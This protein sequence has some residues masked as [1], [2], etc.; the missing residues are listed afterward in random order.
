MLRDETDLRRR[1]IYI[2]RT[3][4]IHREHAVNRIEPIALAT[5]NGWQPVR[6]TTAVFPEE[7]KVFTFD[8][9]LVDTQDYIVLFTIKR[10]DRDGADRY[11]TDE[12]CEPYQIL[13]EFEALSAD[14]RR[15]R[16]TRTGIDR[17]FV[18]PG[19]VILP[20]GNGKCAFPHMEF[21]ATENG[22]I[23]PLSENLAKIDVFRGDLDFMGARQTIFGRHFALPGRHPTQ[24][25]GA[26][27]WES[28][29]ECFEAI[30]RLL[31]RHDSTRP[32]GELAQVSRQVI[33]RLRAA[34]TNSEL[35][36]G[37]GR[38]VAALHERLAILLPKLQK[39]IEYVDEIASTLAD[40][41]EVKHRVQAFVETE[42]QAALEAM[43]DELRAEVRA[44]L[45]AELATSEE[46][47]TKIR[48]EILELDGRRS[49]LTMELE[50]LL[51]VRDV[52]LKDIRT[53]ISSI[54]EEV[55]KGGEGARQLLDVAK[56]FGAAKPAPS[57]E[58]QTDTPWSRPVERKGS[59][60]AL[61]QIPQRIA[62]AA[63]KM[64][65]DVESMAMLDVTVR[66]GEVG[67]LAG[68]E[69]PLMLDVYAEAAF[70][71][72]IRRM[73]LDPSVLG[74]EDLWTHPLRKEATT[75]A[76]AWASALEQP[77]LGHL[78]VLEDV[79]AA[80]LSDWFT[81]FARLFRRCRPA[82]LMIVATRRRMSIEKQKSPESPEIVLT[83]RSSNSPAAALLV[84]GGVARV[85]AG[86]L[87]S[88]FREEL[89]NDERI[90]LLALCSEKDWFHPEL[91]ARLYALTAA[92]KAWRAAVPNSERLPLRVLG[93]D[94]QK[95][96]ASH[97]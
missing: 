82:N 32:G 64:G 96:S 42:K 59:E 62:A 85:E 18:K 29:P 54:A 55:W 34:Y 89:E 51:D 37:D 26:V 24:I 10:N 48:S 68:H 69:A 36:E 66:S 57:R 94:P 23:V 49:N 53:S 75:L 77:L 70:G 17:L 52:R 4:F 22:W 6:N 58:R 19:G 33:Q 7:G 41:P 88:P 65:F 40:A 28:D 3:L 30:A 79:D 31:K 46:A 71:G 35:L 97:D 91:A 16:A 5:E 9:R 81:T 93:L 43:K 72:S 56:Q 63:Q 90:A 95:E 78:V 44:S 92:A 1:S 38:E 14:E 67:I 60:F 47:K 13:P 84:H 73:P 2:G 21:D 80:S 25:D 86:S 11:L 27:N 87:T 74:A 12:V 15:I 20:L 50:R 83:P 76:L 8:P 39:S 45:A 61:S